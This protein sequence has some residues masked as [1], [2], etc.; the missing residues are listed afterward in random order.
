[1]L[2]EGKAL[3]YNTNSKYGVNLNVFSSAVI[4]NL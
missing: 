4:T 1:M 2:M 3:H